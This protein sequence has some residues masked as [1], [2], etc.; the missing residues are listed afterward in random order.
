MGGDAELTVRWVR[1]RTGGSRRQRGAARGQIP[2]PGTCLW[3]R[4][5]WWWVGCLRRK[6]EKWARGLGGWWGQRPGGTCG[7]RTGWWGRAVGRGFGSWRS[8][9]AQA[10][11]REVT[12]DDRE[13]SRVGRRCGGCGGG[14]G[15]GNTCVCKDA[16]GGKT[17]LSMK[18]T[19]KRGRETRN[20]WQPGSWQGSGVSFKEGWAHRRLPEG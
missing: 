1:G 8:L 6:K 19:Q 14:Q 9:C 3:L 11:S 12:R 17:G 10:G 13:N 7:L 4:Q 20:A 5:S 15:P 2:E 16:G 18:E